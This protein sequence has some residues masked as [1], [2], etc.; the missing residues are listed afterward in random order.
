MRTCIVGIYWH[1]HFYVYHTLVF[2]ISSAVYAF[3]LLSVAVA[4]GCIRRWKA[5]QISCFDPP[6]LIDL[7]QPPPRQL[8]SLPESASSD[9]DA[10]Q[11][12]IRVHESLSKSDNSNAS[13]SLAAVQRSFAGVA[14][15]CNLGVCAPNKS[16]LS[17]ST[18]CAD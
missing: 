18:T 6:S 17:A 11:P 10:V 2:G 16:S 1:G 14:A 8:P 9:H 13:D 4:R 7:S 15:E 3:Q 12:D 5:A